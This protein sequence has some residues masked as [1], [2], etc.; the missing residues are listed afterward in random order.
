MLLLLPKDIVLLIDGILHRHRMDIVLK[1]YRVH[2]TGGAC[3]EG[4]VLYHG[5]SYNYRW[6]HEVV[7]EEPLYDIRGYDVAFLP[8]NY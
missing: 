7:H 5:L 2:V 6:Y 4:S 3:M 1:E 8:S